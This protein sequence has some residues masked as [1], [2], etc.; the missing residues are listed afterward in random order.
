MDGFVASRLLSGQEKVAGQIA[1]GE[2]RV[3]AAAEGQT[4]YL[5]GGTAAT[6]VL[7][8][9][10]GGGTA[11]LRPVQSCR[12]VPGLA[13]P[14]W[15][16][17][18][19]GAA[20]QEADLDAAAAGQAIGLLRLGLAARAAAAAQRAHEMA[21]EHA[22]TRRQ[23]GKAIGSFGAVQQRTA[24]CQIDVSAA[25]QLIDR[26]VGAYQNRRPDWPLQA[27]IAVEFTAAAARRVQLGAQH[28][29]AAMG[30]FDHRQIRV[31]RG[32]SKSI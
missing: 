8:L 18:E 21:I 6:H 23:F 4:G 22:K 27:E 32:G 28:T 17:V 10:A 11:R 14:P 29:L 16:A 24:S 12:E 5:D 25:T 13:V 19:L 30:Y 1:A 2:L 26:A 20:Q 31:R 15:T 9:P 7:T 3:L